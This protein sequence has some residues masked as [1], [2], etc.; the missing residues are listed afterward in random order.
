METKKVAL[1]CFIGGA[2][3][4]AIALAVNPVL[5][6]L[7]M[8][9]GFA[10]GY[11]SYEFREVRTA[12]IETAVATGIIVV[13]GPIVLVAET[14]AKIF[15]W[16]KH[17]H[18]LFYFSFFL[19]FLFTSGFYAELMKSC[20]NVATSEL[21]GLAFIY[22]VL[23]CS[24]ALS[25]ASGLVKL[26]ELGEKR[27]RTYWFEPWISDY[28]RSVHWEEKEALDYRQIEFSYQ[29][30]LIMVWQGIMVCLKFIFVDLW[31]KIFKGICRLGRFFRDVFVWIH[32]NQRLLC[33]VDSA[34]GGGLSYLCFMRMG[35]PL[36][37]ATQVMAVFFGGLLGA[38]FGVFNWQV[39]SIRLLK[40]RVKNN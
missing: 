37:I 33:G 36:T 14:L 7:G 25:A 40:V 9:A 24:G 22:L 38:V 12:I 30:Y 26:I 23:F 5:W 17:P 6:W 39:V 11:L 35:I 27:F 1:A 18:P 2:I 29:N 15:R 20:D 21:V 32:S 19:G 16:T 3:C 13:V 31:I 34:L 10:A 4:V 8:L 28:D